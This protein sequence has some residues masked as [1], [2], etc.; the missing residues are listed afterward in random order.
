[1][2]VRQTADRTANQAACAS[3]GAMLAHRDSRTIF[4]RTV[5]GKVL[6]PSLRWLAC[7][8]DFKHGEPRR[9][10]SPMTTALPRRGTPELE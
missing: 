4:M 10:C 8:C 2:V 6:L 1:M 9:S 7:R 5:F 3:R